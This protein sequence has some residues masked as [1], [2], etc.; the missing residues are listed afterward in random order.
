[1]A[2]KDWVYNVTPVI[3]FHPG[4]GKLLTYWAGRQAG[5][6]FILIHGGSSD[7][8]A[9]LRELEIEKLAPAAVEESLAMWQW[10]LDRILELQ[11]ELTNNSRFEQIS[12]SCPTQLPLA[13]PVDTIRGSFD[14]FFAA[15]TGFMSDHGLSIEADTSLLDETLGNVWT[16]LDE[17]QA[18]TYRQ[19]F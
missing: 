2:V 15:W 10:R 6:I 14:I 18:S 11:N 19:A 9:M 12:T 5:D 1:M 17:Y 7:V 16:F 3:S 8:M 4:G 13:P